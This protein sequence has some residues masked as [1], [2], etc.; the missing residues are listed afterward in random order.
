MQSLTENTKGDFS[1]MKF[2]YHQKQKHTKN[3]K[4]DLHTRKI[5]CLVL[6]LKFPYADDDTQH[7][8]D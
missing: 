8:L 7:Q 6:P 4:L 5:T 3:F 2:K 1:E